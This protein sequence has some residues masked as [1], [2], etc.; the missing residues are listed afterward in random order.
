M[1]NILRCT[2]ALPCLAL[3]LATVPA[4]AQQTTSHADDTASEA[5]AGAIVVTATKRAE[6]LQSVPISVSAIGG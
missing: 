6:N 4:H 2:V 3:A 1:T 5:P